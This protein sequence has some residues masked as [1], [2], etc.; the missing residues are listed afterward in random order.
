[1][2]RSVTELAELVRGGELSARELVDA[3]LERIDALNPELNAFVDVDDDGA[4]AAA[5]AIG[6][7]DH[8]PFAGVPIAVKN[9]RAVA[10]RPLTLGADLMGDLTPTHDHN[11]TARL[12]AAGFVIVGTTSLPEWGISPV[13]ESRRHGATRNP[14]DL[15]R[16]PGG[17]SGGSAAA[18]AAGMVPIATGND[19][20]G[21]L[22]IPAACCGLVG[23]KPQRGRISLAP[24]VGEQFLV[25]DGVLTR[26]VHETARLLDVLAGP[27]LGDTSWAPPPSE[28]FAVTA[29]REP[30]RLRIAL[31]TTMALLEADLHPAC[32]RAAHDASALLAEL[33]HDIEEV[34]PPW[35]VPGLL[36]LFTAVFGPA[37]C[38]QIASAPRLAGRALEEDDIE[39]LSWA[40]WER[41]T[42]IDAVEALLAM[43]QLQA[44][45]R[46]V[47]TWADAYDAI[48]TPALAQPPVPIGELDPCG[49]DPVGT[50]V[51]GGHFTPYTAISNVTG[52]PAISLPLYEDDLGLPL[53]VQLIG[54]PAQEGAL[55]ALAA[56]I[57]AARPWAD[58]RAAV[59]A[60]S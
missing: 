41:V 15:T 8:R 35:R 51:R 46:G 14:W 20:G 42:T 28:P 55:L 10:G 31:T 13:T 56:Q 34:A 21:S 11:V 26:T 54:R 7:A 37:L 29:A 53:A 43:R 2:V 39:P 47:V 12:R 16:T 27:A 33:G 48:L 18:V 58:R 44:F 17:S 30:G 25:Q 52:S 19:G 45:G 23:L 5:D 59:A 60:G 22:R 38:A 57:E 9:N 50:F 24:D 6:P 4:R 49:P 32:E 36:D 3:S 40:L 1:M